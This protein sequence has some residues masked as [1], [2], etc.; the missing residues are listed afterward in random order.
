MQPG[1]NWSKIHTGPY[2]VSIES[3][4]YSEENT[5]TNM[6]QTGLIHTGPYNVGINHSS[7]QRKTQRP[8]WIK[9][10]IHTGPYNVGI[11]SF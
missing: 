4:Q 10:K 5:K 6:D 11:E 2:N 9:L 3:F 8:T 7:M 1:S